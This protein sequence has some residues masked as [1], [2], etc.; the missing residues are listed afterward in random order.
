MVVHWRAEQGR[1]AALASQIACPP[2]T[3]RAGNLSGYCTPGGDELA[4]RILGGD[5][6]LAAATERVAELESQE[7]LWVPLLHETR[8]AATAGGITARGTA[9]GEWPGGLSSAAAW[10]LA[11]TVGRRTSIQEVP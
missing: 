8:L 7:V 10:K 11:D 5:L 6:E 3:G 4:A 2:D 1:Q 9:A